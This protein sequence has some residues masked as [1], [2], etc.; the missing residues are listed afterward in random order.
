MWL[1]AKS[2]PLVVFEGKKVKPLGG[3]QYE[4][5]GTFS[6][7]GVAKPL[8]ITVQARQ[9]PAEK[10]AKLGLGEENWV[11]VRGEF[12]V[13]LSDYGIERPEMTLAKVNDE[14]TVKV[15]LFA[16]EEK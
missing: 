7:K 10:A 4:V 15:S 11:R 3:D 2:S 12:K 6:V 8:T 5:S 9:I 14:W 1:D 13:R 16:K